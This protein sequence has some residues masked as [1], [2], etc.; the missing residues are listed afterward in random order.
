[1][2]KPDD[3]EFMISLFKNSGGIKNVANLELFFQTYSRNPK[4]FKG[5]GIESVEMYGILKNKDDL[6]IYILIMSIGTLISQIIV[7]PFLFTHVSFVKVNLKN[8]IKM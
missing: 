8:A 6:W 2:Y 4:P 7:W 1:M 5:Q 3:R